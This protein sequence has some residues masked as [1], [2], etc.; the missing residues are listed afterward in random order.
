MLSPRALNASTAA[1]LTQNIIELQ[2][3]GISVGTMTEAATTDPEPQEAIQERNDAEISFYRSWAI[4]ALELENEGQIFLAFSTR[5][6]IKNMLSLCD[7]YPDEMAIT[8]GT[9]DALKLNPYRLANLAAR[10]DPLQL[11]L[12]KLNSMLRMVFIARYEGYGT[13]LRELV[14]RLGFEY[15]PY[16]S[17]AV[18]RVRTNEFYDMPH[19]SLDD[20]SPYQFFLNSSWS[21]IN[22]RLQLDKIDGEMNRHTYRRLKVDSQP[23]L[24]FFRLLCHA[25]A[26]YDHESIHRALL[27]WVSKPWLRRPALED[28]AVR[29]EF[30]AIAAQVNNDLIDLDYTSN[31]CSQLVEETRLGIIKTAQT[32]LTDI[33]WHTE[34]GLITSFEGRR[35]PSA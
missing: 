34:T 23:L 6:Q 13:F 25:N 3:D 30:M 27:V 9:F 17:D 7:R 19:H 2:R 35:R 24:R 10:D 14:T 33:T 16:S 18:P 12:Y 4:Y 15:P 31:N 11:A 28:Q 22:L 1:Q 20:T 29:G 32:Y 8:L 21:R 26:D 5:R